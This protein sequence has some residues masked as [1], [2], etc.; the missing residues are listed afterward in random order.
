MSE[1]VVQAQKERDAGNYRGALDLLRPFLLAVAAAGAQRRGG[2]ERLLP[3]L[4]QLQGRVTA[5]TGVRVF[6][7]T[8]PARLFAGARPGCSVG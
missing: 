8:G 3:P 4:A 7:T 6:G 2:G 1:M 5:R